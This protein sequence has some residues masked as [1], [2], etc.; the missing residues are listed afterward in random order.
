MIIIEGIPEK[1]VDPRS[2]TVAKRTVDMAKKY[3]DKI[4][5][6][7]PLRY[8]PELPKSKGG[9]SNITLPLSKPK[10]AGGFV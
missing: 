9:F 1:G 6:E 5:K 7:G 10:K 2:Y 4:F 8:P 3:I